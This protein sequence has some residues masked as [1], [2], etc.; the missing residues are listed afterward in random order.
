VD[1]LVAL[2]V[3]LLLLTVAA[4]LVNRQVTSAVPIPAI[5]EKR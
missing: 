3:V 4:V 2:A 5:E 1:R